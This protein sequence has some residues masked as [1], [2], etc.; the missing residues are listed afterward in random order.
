MQPV[1]ISQLPSEVAVVCTER[2][3]S[4]GSETQEKQAFSSWTLV[5]GIHVLKILTLNLLPSATSP[6]PE[7][8]F[9]FFC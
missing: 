1:D 7:E 6:A 3:H 2:A 8:N 5:D 4:L 9:F